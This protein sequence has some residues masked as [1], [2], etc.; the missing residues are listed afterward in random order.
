MDA[1]SHTTGQG[2][3]IQ[4]KHLGNIKYTTSLTPIDQIS[5]SIAP[6]S[7]PGSISA[8]YLI[9]AAFTGAVTHKGTF[10]LTPEKVEARSEPIDRAK[11]ADKV[12]GTLTES[13]TPPSGS[14]YN[15]AAI[16]DD[17]GTLREHVIPTVVL[18][19]PVALAPVNTV[20][21]TTP[22][23]SWTAVTGAT[24]YFLTIVDLTTPEVIMGD[25][26][27][28]SFT[29]SSSTLLKPGDT[30][31]WSVQALDNNGDVSALSNSLEFA[32]AFGSM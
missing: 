23:F 28:N 22:T 13:V 31:V 30:Y 8:P 17:S 6:N 25:V 1:I 5:A 32:V 11:V 12:F 24:F 19:A 15:I 27:S 29:P 10:K 2:D 21:T 14:P 18:A 9:D 7:T 4:K 26:I 20:F 3:D 16:V